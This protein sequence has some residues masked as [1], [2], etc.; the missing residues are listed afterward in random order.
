MNEVERDIHELERE[1]ARCRERL[2]HAAK[3]AEMGKMVAVVAHELSQPLLGIKA[4]AQI[5][6]RHCEQDDFIEPKLRLIVEQATV[7]EEILNNLRQFVRQQDVEAQPIDPA[8]PVRA[9]LALFSERAKKKRVTLELR[10]QDD[11]PDVLGNAAHY[12]QVAANLIGN[13]IDAVK[14]E[15]HAEI[16]VSVDA[17]GDRARMRIVDSGAGIPDSVR[18]KLFEPFYT[19]KGPEDGTGLGLSICREILDLYG[20]S[21]RLMEPE[22]LARDFGPDFRTGFE[23]LFAPVGTQGEGDGPEGE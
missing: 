19:T 1:L 8:P 18:D 13:A 9:A 16:R 11:L 7:M 17:V 21:I 20:G 14:D 12:Q 10:C 2:F 15:A 3:L 4:F 6:H 22:E 23:V 5:L